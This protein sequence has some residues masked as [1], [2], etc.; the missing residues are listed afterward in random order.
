MEDTPPKKPDGATYS[1]ALT[2]VSF[3]FLVDDLSRTLELI[4]YAV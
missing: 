1:R 2:G 4:D 3:N